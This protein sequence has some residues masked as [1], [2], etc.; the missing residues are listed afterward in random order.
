MSTRGAHSCV[1]ST[2]T[3]RPD[4]TSIVSSS[5]ERRQRAHH[6]RRRSASRAR[7]GRCR[8]RRPG[9][10]AARRPRGRGCSCSIRSGAS[11]CQDRAVS[12]V[13]RG[14]RTGR[15]PSMS[16]LLSSERRSAKRSGDRLG[17][18][19]GRA[20]SRRRAPRPRSPGRGSGPGRG[21]RPRRAARRRPP[22]SPG[23]ASSGPRRS[24]ARAAV[25]SSM[26]STRV[27]PSTA[28]R[29]LR[30]ADQPIETWS[31]CMRRRRDRVDR[32]RHGEPL[33]LGDD[34]GLRVLGDHVPG[35]DARV[36][37]EERRAGRGCG[38]RRGTGRCAAR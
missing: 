9:R 3:G 23:P 14:A 27:S 12:V 1:R 34:R 31:S 28:R 36:V 13:P 18:R 4:C 10:R 15:A 11:V 35:V 24:S 33:E 2:P 16:M 38:R 25:S 17:G 29:S 26:A 30:A 7:R 20:A 5:L 22:R 6:A 32:R 8:R 21:R 19:H 37:G